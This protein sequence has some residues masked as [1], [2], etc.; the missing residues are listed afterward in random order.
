[1]RKA[2]DQLQQTSSGG[3]AYRARR[4]RPRI[5]AL[6]ATAL[7]ALLGGCYRHSDMALQPKYWK[8]YRPSEFFADG[9]SERP[10]P[11]G[12]VPQEELRTDREFYF[13]LD[14]KGNTIDHLPATY[15]DGTP[16]PSK[17]PEMQ[18]LLERGQQ[19]FNIYCIVCHGQL[20]YGDGMVVQ[21]GFTTPPSYHADKLLHHEPIG[22]F[23]YVMSNGYGAMYS[24]S[25]RINPA[26]RW[27]IAA[28]IKALQLSQNPT[29]DDLS[30]AQAL[31][32]PNA[33]TTVEG[34]PAT[35]G[36]K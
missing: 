13:G 35:G 12:V 30:R 5:A 32:P 28:Y 2:T 9:Q 26:D 18:A 16:F 4:V 33:A 10:L 24:Y 7:V 31:V 22:H 6:A 36:G 19:R 8:I 3:N 23:F 27:A 1:M 15:P 21:R 20:G 17:G 11:E 25:E 14:L 34:S 29:A